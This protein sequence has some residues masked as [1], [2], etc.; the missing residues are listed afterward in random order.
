VYGLEYSTGASRLFG[1]TGGLVSRVYLKSGISG[2]SIQMTGKN[3]S[4]ASSGAPQGVIHTPDGKSIRVKLDISK[5]SSGT[6][7]VGWRELTDEY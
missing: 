2:V 3:T 7:H 6:R 5:I 4:P 1:D